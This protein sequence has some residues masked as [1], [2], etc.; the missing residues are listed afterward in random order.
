MNRPLARRLC[1]GVLIGVIVCAAAMLGYNRLNRPTTITAVFTS[2]PSIY[3]G[4]D[5]RVAGVK[6]GTISAIQPEG[7][8]VRLTFRVDKDVPI[9][10]NAQ[11]IIVAE[12]LIAA[13]YVQLS[14][15]YETTGPTMRDGD[16][17]PLDR[18]AVPVEWDEVKD[19]LDRLA[20]ALGPTNGAP[21]GSLGRFFDSAAAAMDGNGDKLRQ[22]LKELSG[23]AR[24]LGEGSG[25]IVDI[26]KNLQRF[27]TALRDSNQEIVQFEDR[28]A[29]LSSVLDGNR[30]DLDGALS[31]LSV[32]V[33][34]VQRFV[35]AT[36]DRTSEQVVRLADVT[37]NLADNK[38]EVEELLH[39]FP[40]VL[41]NGYNIY[42]P[43]T[44]GGGGTFVF[45][46]FSNLPQLLCGA[47]VTNTNNNPTETA[48]KC[49]EYLGPL[50]RLFNFNTLPIAW[51]P[52]LKPSV[53]PDRL[54]YTEPGLIPGAP[55]APESQRPAPQGLP[56]MLLPAEAQPK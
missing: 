3:I 34:D 42:D 26:L 22:T 33:G 15:P 49:A 14:P 23:V 10:A 40:N 46:G 2:A 53:P 4:D 28:L 13:R 54:I 31:T 24:I 19:Q 5:V 9:P 18:T 11:A 30:S 36:R 16:V 38:G 32:A 50:M 6:A 37:Q 43:L 39:I 29:T 27:V 35:A 21:T 25:N 47:L 8:T 7:T 51:N 44:G 48:K 41:A 12:N 45:S 1:A 55:A 56:D 52:F 20:V 17:I